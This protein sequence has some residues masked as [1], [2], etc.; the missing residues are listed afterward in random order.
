MRTIT[1]LLVPLSLAQGL[2]HLRCPI[3]CLLKKLAPKKMFSLEVYST[4]A[5]PRGS[6]AEASPINFLRQI[7]LKHSK[8]TIE[9]ETVWLLYKRHFQTI[10]ELHSTNLMLPLNLSGTEL[11]GLPLSEWTSGQSHCHGITHH[12]T[13]S[14]QRQDLAIIN[15]SVISKR[16]HISIQR[17][18]TRPTCYE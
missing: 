9:L 7:S 2:G 4:T 15:H 3:K 18:G 17:S 1:V 13:F 10:C 8:H 11:L 6:L 16:S 12:C 5:P 14:A